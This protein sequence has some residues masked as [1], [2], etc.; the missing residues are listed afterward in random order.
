MQVDVG[1]P[2]R[3]GGGIVGAFQS[4]ATQLVQQQVSDRRKPQPQLVGPHRGRAG[5]VSKQIQLLASKSSTSSAGAFPCAS[6]NTHRKNSSTC[7][8]F[9]PIL[10]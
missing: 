4:P 8:G 5:P 1:E 7:S 9:T 2:F 6:T 10:L 3:M